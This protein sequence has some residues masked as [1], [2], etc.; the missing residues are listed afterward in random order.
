[1]T[2]LAQRELTG[3]TQQWGIV[4]YAA[5]SERLGDAR[6]QQVTTTQSDEMRWITQK[7]Y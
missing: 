5:V 1:M 7:S 6:M 3:V 4:G 2:R